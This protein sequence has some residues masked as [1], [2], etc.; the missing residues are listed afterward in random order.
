VRKRKLFRIARYGFYLIITA[1]LIVIIFMLYRRVDTLEATLKQVTEQVTAQVIAQINATEAA[2][3]EELDMKTEVITGSTQAATALV[4]YEITAGTT[5]TG[6][7]I[8]MTDEGIQQINAVYTGILAELEK[9]TLD[10]LYTEVVLIDLEQEAGLLFK[11]GK[12]LQAS[13]LYETIADAQ[14]EN[15]EARFFYL[16]SLFLGN[17]LDRTNYRRIKEG[18]LV[19]ERNGYERAE[20]REVL[21]YIDIEERGLEMELFQ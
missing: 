18:F 9:R 11:E 20:I 8:M 2:I 6:R 3:L 15:T 10:S 14:P 12:Y 19:L 7:R 5:V 17:K 13:A 4:I 1:I 21:E 16:Y